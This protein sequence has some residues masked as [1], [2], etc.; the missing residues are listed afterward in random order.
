MTAGGPLRL[1]APLGNSS[2]V[3]H[4]NSRLVPIKSRVGFTINVKSCHVRPKESAAIVKLWV[5]IDPKVSPI[6]SQRQN[7]GNHPHTFGDALTSHEVV[8]I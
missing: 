4:Q 2:T 1:R 6:T 7:R 3:E 5:V 8:L